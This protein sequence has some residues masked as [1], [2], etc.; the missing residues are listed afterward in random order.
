MNLRRQRQ[1]RKRG[2]GIT[3]AQF[4][5]GHRPANNEAAEDVEDKLEAFGNSDRELNRHRHG[6]GRRR[7][8]GVSGSTGV[9]FF[10][11]VG[12]SEVTTSGSW[13]LFSA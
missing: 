8:A 12:G 1:R 6:L 11:P 7:R 3:V 2:L 5:P 10:L 4:D 13:R 9:R